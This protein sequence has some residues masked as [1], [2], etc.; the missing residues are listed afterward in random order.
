M[1]KLTTTVLMIM[2]VFMVMTTIT[3]SEDVDVLQMYDKNNDGMIDADERLILDI[4]IESGRITV[5]ES[6]MAA[7]FTT[8]DT[9]ILN[10][11]IQDFAMG[12]VNDQTPVVESTVAPVVVPVVES[13]VDPEPAAPVVPEPVEP[14]TQNAAPAIGVVGIVGIIVGII[15]LAMIL[16]KRG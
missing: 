3:A 12:D 15:L 10:D 11:E 6:T 8:D 1:K 9:I 7:M 4:D 13:V 2:T 16:R 5:D 14:E